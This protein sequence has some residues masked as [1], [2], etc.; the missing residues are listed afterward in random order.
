MSVEHGPRLKIQISLKNF[1]WTS[2]TFRLIDHVDPEGLQDLSLSEV[3]DPDFSEDRNCDRGHDFFDELQ[4]R[5]IEAI[6]NG[7]AGPQLYNEGWA[8]SEKGKVP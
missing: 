6:F 8:D 5:K 2:F 7:I 3:T 1:S 4:N